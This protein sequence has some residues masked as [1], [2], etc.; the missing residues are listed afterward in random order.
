MSAHEASVV[1]GRANQQPLTVILRRSPK[2]S[3][4]GWTATK[5]VSSALTYRACWDWMD[6][7]F[8]PFIPAKAGI[9]ALCSDLNSPVNKLGPRFRGDERQM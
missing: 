9:Q 7:P 3:L 1:P 8:L 5:C 6:A 4:E 2:A